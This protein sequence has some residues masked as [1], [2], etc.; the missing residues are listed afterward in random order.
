MV[1]AGVDAS[2]VGK[3]SNDT[4]V[5]TTIMQYVKSPAMQAYHY[6]FVTHQALEEVG[7]FNGI[8]DLTAS[9]ARAVRDRMEEMLASVNMT[10]GSED[11][12]Q[13]RLANLIDIAVTETIPGT[14]PMFSQRD[15]DGKRA[16]TED[17][18]ARFNTLNQRFANITG[19]SKPT[20]QPAG[21]YRL[22]ISPYDPRFATRATSMRSGT[23]LMTILDDDVQRFA[24]DN[25]SGTYDYSRLEHYRNVENM[26]TLYED[27][28]TDTIGPLWSQED[29]LGLAALRPYM[30]NE[31]Y[32][33]ALNWLR[34]DSDANG[35]PR[36]VV[37]P[38]MAAR[39]R[40]L[41]D[42]LGSQG[43]EYSVQK[44]KNPGQLKVRLTDSRA[45]I[46]LV[47]KDAQYIGRVYDNGVQVYFSPKPEQGQLSD[48]TPRETVDLVRFVRGEEVR[49]H[50]TGE[51]LGQGAGDGYRNGG[52]TA[53]FAL[54]PGKEIYMDDKH[55]NVAKVYYD[56]EGGETA[57]QTAENDLREAIEQARNMVASQLDV[58]G[59]VEAYN[60]LADDD[61]LGVDDLAPEYAGD[62]TIAGLREA[63]WNALTEQSGMLLDPGY[64][65]DDYWQAYRGAGE[66]AMEAAG[67][68]PKDRDNEVYVTAAQA[69]VAPMTTAARIMEEDKAAGLQHHADLVIDNMI[70]SFDPD[71]QGLRFNPNKVAAYMSANQSQWRNRDKIISGLRATGIPAAE[72]RGED[73]EAGLVADRLITFNEDTAYDIVG[74]NVPDDIH[75][76][77][78]SLGETITDTLRQKAIEPTSIR[79]DDQGIIH[80]DATR[81]VRP[82]S[83]NAQISGE[84][85]QIF[86][87]DL[88]HGG[89]VTRY[90]G[91][92][93]HMFFPGYEARVLDQKPGENLSIEQRTRLIGFEQRLNEAVRDQLVED[94]IGIN[95]SKGNV[96]SVNGVYRNLYGHQYPVDFFERS[97]EEGMDPSWRDAISQTELRRVIYPKEFRDGS[98]MMAENNYRKNAERFGVDER[99]DNSREPYIRSGKRNLAIIDPAVAPGMYDPDVTATAAGHG[100]VRFLTEGATVDKHGV[101]TPSPDANDRVPLMKHP[102]TWA[103]EFNPHDRRNMTVSNLLQASQIT[104]LKVNTAMGQI[105]G[106]NFEDGIVVSKEFAETYQIRD[107]AG[108]MRPLMAG[109]KLSDFHGNKGVIALVVDREMDPD[110][111]ARRGIWDQVEF[112]RQNPELEVVMSPFSPISRL[113][114]GT[115]REL[116]TNPK[117]LRV[118]DENGVWHEREGHMGELNF[119]VTHMAVDAKTNEYDD[120]AVA[121]GKGR[122]ISNQL[123]WGLQQHGAYDV[124]EDLFANNSAGAATVKETLVALGMDLTDT[125]ELHI[126]L[127]ERAYDEDNEH[128]RK[129]FA[130]P[131]LELNSRGRLAMNT[132]RDDFGLAISKSGGVME[133]PFPL[134]M[135]TGDETPELDNGTFGLPVMSSRMRNQQ[136]LLDGSISKHDFTRNY[137]EIFEAATQYRYY[138][139]GGALRKEDERKGVTREQI[140]EG[141]VKQAQS[142]YETM[143]AKLTER[144]VEGKHNMFKEQVM[145]YRAPNSA[146][147]VWS[148]NPNVDIDAIV[149]S[150]SMAQTLGVKEGDHTLMWRD[151]VLRGAGVSYMRVVI[152]PEVVGVQVNPTIAAM[153]DGDFDGDSVGLKGNLSPKAHAQAMEKFSIGAKMLD[154]GSYGAKAEKLGGAKRYELAVANNLDLEVARKAGMFE[155]D[156]E[157]AKYPERYPEGASVDFFDDITDRI[158]D[159]YT[160]IAL[161]ERAYAAGEVDTQAYVARRDELLDERAGYMREV[162][163]QVQG[164]LQNKGKNIFLDFSSGAKH[165]ESCRQLYEV[166]GKGSASKI[167][168]MLRYAGFEDDGNGNLVVHAGTLSTA[169]DNEESQY[170]MCSKDAYTG[171]AGKHSQHAIQYLRA[172]GLVGEANE[173]ARVATQGLLSAKHSAADAKRRV[174]MVDTVLRDQWSGYQ[175][176]ITPDANGNISWA[177]VMDSDGTPMQATT[178]QWA[179][180]M[181]A[182]INSKEGMDTFVGLNQINKVARALSDEHGFIVNT[183]RENW[184]E[185]PEGKA[186]LA[187]DQ[188]ISDGKLSDLVALAREGASLYEGVNAAAAP[189]AIHHN[190]K[191]AQGTLAIE[192]KDKQS[193]VTLEE[194]IGIGAKDVGQDF[195]VKSKSAREYAYVPKQHMRT[196]E[197]VAVAVDAPVAADVAVQTAQMHPQGEQALD[198]APADNN[199]GV[200]ADD[201]AVKERDVD[202]T[203][204]VRR[205][206]Y[207]RVENTATQF[208]RRDGVAYEAGKE[209]VQEDGPAYGG[210]DPVAQQYAQRMAQREAGQ[211][212]FAQ[213]Q[214]EPVQ[215]ASAPQ[216]QAQGGFNG[217][218]WA[219]RQHTQEDVPPVAHNAHPDVT[220][221]DPVDADGLSQQDMMR[222]ANERANMQ[223]R[224]NGVLDQA[225]DT[226]RDRDAGGFER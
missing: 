191:V 133:L 58:Y 155:M 50:A 160:D 189:R 141:L 168:A 75:P 171:V 11:L 29:A 114:M 181:D 97:L 152:D 38:N 31:E 69:A 113:N 74:D 156:R 9:Q 37:D 88:E 217:S 108:A 206:A 107:A 61:T 99:N 130:M 112:Y 104:G 100:V 174:F 105:G 136:E 188:M 8:D 79:I 173:V 193:G 64:T 209:P 121:E 129:R 73:F 187:L 3:I 30:K 7:K 91:S 184:H 176:D 39:A 203:P 20:S 150:P 200:V 71:E 42:Y 117:P 137:M 1:Y 34:A 192:T 18:K 44:D 86:L 126:G 147:A 172:Q 116:M 81:K 223:A 23:R 153:H 182:I 135:A 131:P 159:V 10:I 225:N 72:L 119:I 214:R 40:A 143:A 102:D 178:A 19:M 55:H 101:V 120:E 15:A 12:S 157:D 215:A 199:A 26:V 54:A 66:A 134:T 185:W 35:N 163:D 57:A 70:G 201:V 144:H 167:D 13:Q 202:Q 47:D 93:N 169:R 28:G 59:L 216:S 123:V 158:N 224:V 197:P 21:G 205:R 190:R 56:K 17:G 103:M 83:A 48:I 162:N 179:K 96:T 183:D 212:G 5:A 4:K 94:A 115:S 165:I 222:I 27:N 98:T 49:N 151:P 207:A 127:D 41:L 46:R 211:R 60:Q 208:V 138:A 77:L 63:Y 111:A 89:V 53:R 52:S 132:M 219:A 90:A 198:A 87:P 51:V 221:A 45:D 220:Q 125:G 196:P 65:Q 175:L 106:W 213:P 67:L 109:D 24:V 180:Q 226:A 62:D 210:V 186:P 145:G 166:G 128:A 154:L 84:I 110:E 78:V 148:A 146:T 142:N 140:M 92:E 118:Q 95:T 161:N 36:T 139:E 122:K 80:W 177:P 204:T 6:E 25:T 68:D 33:E 124:I 82:A 43:I 170:A 22:P 32:R 164:G 2:L 218:V 195:V 149:V 14:Q 85:G 16:F 194:T 76:M